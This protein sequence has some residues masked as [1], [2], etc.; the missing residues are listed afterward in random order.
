VVDDEVALLVSEEVELIVV[1][2]ICPLCGEVT[3]TVVVTVGVKVIIDIGGNCSAFKWRF[4]CS[5]LMSCTSSVA[6]PDLVERPSNVTR[7]F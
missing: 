7:E 2:G 1:V 4:A 3:V 5:S 6:W